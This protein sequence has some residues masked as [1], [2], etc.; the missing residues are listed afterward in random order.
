MLEVLS[1]DYIRTAAQGLSRRPPWSC[2]QVSERA[3][4][5]ADGGGTPG[6]L[7]AGGA[8]LTETIFSW[9]GSRWVYESIES[10][11]LP[12]RPGASLF[13]GVVVVVVNLLTDSPVRRGRP[14]HQ[15]RLMA[16]STHV[17]QS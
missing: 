10:R 14:A 6:R 1:R 3:P 5:R 9:P 7:A 12:H 16:V 15:V 17:R 8:I 4:P 2:R 13:I 11:D